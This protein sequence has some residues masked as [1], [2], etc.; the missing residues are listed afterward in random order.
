MAAAENPI[1]QH[2]GTHQE[3]AGGKAPGLVRGCGTN[4]DES[5]SAVSICLAWNG[6][7]LFGN[8][9]SKLMNK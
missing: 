8:M 7:F 5:L 3:E 4:E 6:R 9:E 2:P 1:R